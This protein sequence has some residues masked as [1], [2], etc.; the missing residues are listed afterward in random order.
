V[1]QP[2]AGDSIVK[3]LLLSIL[4]L[5]VIVAGSGVYYVQTKYLGIGLPWVSSIDIPEIPKTEEPKSV[6]EAGDKGSIYFATK[7]PYDFSRVLTGFDKLPSHSGMGELFLPVGASAESPVPA[8]I[9]VPG[10]GGSNPDREPEYARIF[11]ELGI[12]AFVLDYYT[13]RGTGDEE[14]YIRKVLSATE[15]DILVDAYSALNLLNTHPAIDGA[16]VGITGYSYGG[17]VTRYALD[18]RVKQIVAPDVAPFAL[19]MSFYGPCHQ[20]LGEDA[21]TGGA[22]L[23]IFGDSDN[24]VDPVACK[25]VEKI[26]AAN[27]TS[28]ESHMIE[29]AGHAWE[30]S[31]P[32]EVA[33]NPYV[34]GC[35]FTYDPKTGQPLV[36]GEAVAHPAPD[37]TRGERA[38]TRTSISIE[39]P[40]CIGEGYLIG[41]NPEADAQAKAIMVEFLKKQGFAKAETANTEAGT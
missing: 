4:A 19:H 20:T 14:H 26:L 15:A 2:L 9:I 16:N 18:P 7:S 32:L 10:S 24:S 36:D 12:A 6:L 8:I 27:G 40:H 33:D 5:V 3:K 37:A 35:D 23:A 41:S 31:R 25:R 13:P 22:Y 39:T 38:Y 34:R 29:G 30:V 11:N 21:T 28:V 17:M 1:V